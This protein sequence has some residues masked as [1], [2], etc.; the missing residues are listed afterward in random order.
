MS[1]QQSVTASNRSSTASIIENLKFSAPIVVYAVNIIGLCIGGAGLW[2]P[3]ALLVFTSLAVDELIGDDRSEPEDPPLWMI[4]LFC[5][6]S[7]AMIAG[8]LLLL[9]HY[10]TPA[11][12]IGLVVALRHVGV[13]LEA[14]REATSAWQ[15][16]FSILGHIIF[17]SLSLSVMHELSHRI[18][19]PF[20]LFIG[21][22]IGA[23]NLEPWLMLHH[24]YVHHIQIGLRSDPSTSR[25]G[26]TLYAFAWRAIAGNMAHFQEREKERLA[27]RNKAYWSLSNRVLTGWIM[28]GVVAAICAYIAGFAGVAVFLLIST[29][30]RFVLEGIGYI[31]HYGLV[32]APGEPITAHLNWDVYRKVTNSMLFNVGRHADHHLHGTRPGGLLKIQDRAPCL[33]KSYMGLLFMAYVP[34]LYM[35]YMK[36]H[37]ANWDRNFATEAELQYMREQGIPHEEP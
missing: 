9:L 16:A 3:L 12:P 21:R 8:S 33:P 2:A 4:D 25:R 35:H 36:P 11:D 5:Y 20:A 18:D 28:I 13:D 22:V 27:R 17:F 37:L 29:Q 30:S 26:E 31:E 14:A 24:P 7:V 6:L 32:R 19:N 1:S 23:L 15:L 10:F 34:P